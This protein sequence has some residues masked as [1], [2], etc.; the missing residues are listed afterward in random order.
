MLNGE[1]NFTR[2]IDTSVQGR[3]LKSI[4]DLPLKR[5]RLAFVR[6]VIQIVKLFVVEEGSCPGSVGAWY[7]RVFQ[8]KRNYWSTGRFFIPGNVHLL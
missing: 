8:R 4:I 5:Q 6:D 1:D 3:P 2:R 7:V